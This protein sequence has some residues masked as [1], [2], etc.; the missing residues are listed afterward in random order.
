MTNTL[1][2]MPAKVTEIMVETMRKNTELSINF[3][4]EVEKNQREALKSVSEAMN[5]EMPF[6]S[7]VWDTQINMMEQGMKMVDGMYEKLSS[8]MKK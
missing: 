2:E 7:K 1:L 5:M 8:V 4:K 6:D 3:M